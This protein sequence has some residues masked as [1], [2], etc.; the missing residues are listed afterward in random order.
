M[1][2]E[3]N[4]IMVLIISDKTF[5]IITPQYKSRDEVFRLQQLGVISKYLKN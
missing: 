2:V 3:Y 5:G 1:L 4:R